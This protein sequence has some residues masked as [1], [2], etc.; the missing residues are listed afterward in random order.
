MYLVL[1]IFTVVAFTCILMGTLRG[2]SLLHEKLLANVL[3][4]PMLF[5]ESTP[6]GRIVNRFS[7]DIDSL[8]VTMPAIIRSW[9]ACFFTV[10]CH[11]IMGHLIFAPSGLVFLKTKFRL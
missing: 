9:T 5:F 1:A 11:T 4:A 8:D 6:I 10:S 3:K 2:A 7:K